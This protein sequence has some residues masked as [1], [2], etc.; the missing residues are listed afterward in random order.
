MRLPYSLLALAFAVLA[1]PAAA[2]DYGVLSQADLDAN[3]GATGV[4][5]RC[6]V[7]VEGSL[8]FYD[9]AGGDVLLYDPSS[10]SDVGTL[11]RK[12]DI[13]AAAGF[14]VDR[15]H[16]IF[17]QA[18]DGVARTFFAF[19]DGTDEAVLLFDG[20]GDTLSRLVAPAE[21]AGTYALAASGSALYLGRVAFRGA[22]ED[23]VYSVATTG[24]DQTPAVVVQNAD[25]DLLDLDVASD[26]SLYAVSS[27]FG[28]RSKAW[29][30]SGICRNTGAKARAPIGLSCAVISI[31][32][33]RASSVG[34]PLKARTRLPT[35]SA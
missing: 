27:E 5:P 6:L 28:A 30:I 21:A 4:E 25:L 3:T 24:A 23:G 14:T 16:A 22:P 8:L 35:S 29:R 19:G 9:S 10:G 15:C 11:L 1:L 32:R 2:Q 34:T 33:A 26:G 17:F 12:A 13:D 20:D 7:A 31:T 18:E